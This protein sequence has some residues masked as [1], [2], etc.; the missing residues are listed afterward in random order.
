MRLI[1]ES[2]N[3]VQVFSSFFYTKLEAAGVSGVK[4]W[5]KDATK[6][7]FSKRLLLVP[8]H[9]GTHWCLATINF[10]HH[11]LCYYDSMNGTNDR[12]LQLLKQYIMLFYHLH[13]I[14]KWSTD[15]PQDIPQQRN[16]SDCG[17]FMCMYARQLAC[18]GPFNFSQ[19]DISQIRR[20]MIIELVLKKLL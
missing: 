17:V 15:F 14:S 5:M 20:H 1:S 13:A 9:L 11:Q 2:Q 18:S 3:D 7:L 16:H 10:R 8:V 12:C 6:D 19:E 4:H